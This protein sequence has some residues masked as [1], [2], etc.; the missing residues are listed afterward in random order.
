[1][2]FHPQSPPRA[3]RAEIGV[4]ALRALVAELRVTFRFPAARLAAAFAASVVWGMGIAGCAGPLWQGPGGSPRVAN[5]TLHRAELRAQMTPGVPAAPILN[6]MAASY[7]RSGSADSTRLLLKQALAEDPRHT[8]SLAWLSRLDYEAGEIEQAV[9]LLEPVAAEPNPDPEIL[10]NLA[11]IKLAWGEVDTA[12]SLLRAAIDRH[13]HHSPAYGNLGYLHLQ[14]GD[15]KAAESDLE[16][17]I[18][19]DDRIPEFHLNLGIV[20][21]RQQRFEDATRDFERALA[22]DPEFREAHHN[23]GL[24]YKLYL[25]DEA[26]AQAHFQRFLALGGQADQEVAALFRKEGDGKP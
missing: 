16:H 18:Q 13:P 4:V 2:Q 10:T 6:A 9:A 8:P 22:L 24:L 12:E 14:S 17:A 3:D 11:M 5:E 7:W 1:M 19:R 23:L 15:L 26:R 21:R 25:F 20:H